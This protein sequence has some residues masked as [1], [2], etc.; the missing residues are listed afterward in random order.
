[1]MITRVN[2]HSPST[3]VYLLYF[4]HNVYLCLVVRIRLIPPPGRVKTQS[5]LSFNCLPAG[6]TFS[7][8]AMASFSPQG[9]KPTDCVTKVALSVSCQNLLDKDHFSKSDP[10]CVLLMN[11]SGS[12]WCEVNCSFQTFSNTKVCNKIHNQ[13]SRAIGPYADL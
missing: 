1:M 7:R 4:Q 10:L 5:V 8:F 2:V 12:H 13:T 3:E 9:P 11:T 6:Q